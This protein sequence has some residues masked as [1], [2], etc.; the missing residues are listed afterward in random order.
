MRH[1]EAETSCAGRRHKIVNIYCTFMGIMVARYNLPAKATGGHF[2][3]LR[4]GRPYV[5]A[6]LWVVV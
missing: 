4:L 6:T 1:E 5:L 2:C 3:Y